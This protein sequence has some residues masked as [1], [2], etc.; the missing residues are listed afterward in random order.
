MR[1]T[2]LVVLTVV[3]IT[4]SGLSTAWADGTTDPELLYVGPGVGT[5]CGGTSTPSSC[6]VYNGTEVVGLGASPT[7]LDVSLNGTSNTTLENPILLII[8]I[9]TVS[10]SPTGSAPSTIT[11]PGGGTAYLGGNG[12]GYYGWSGA[13]TSTTFSSSSGTVYNALGLIPQGSNSQ[14]FTNWQSAELAVN[15]MTATDFGIYVYT[16]F[17]TPS[18]KGGSSFNVDFV[19]SALP[20]GTFAVAYGCSSWTSVGQMPT[21]DSVGKTYST[22]FTQSGLV[23]GTTPVP[24]PGSL[25]L[26]GTGLLGLGGIVR[27]KFRV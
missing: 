4:I 27:R 23:D 24:E 16:L 22:P 5:T 12:S 9:P 8:G 3:A 21:C 25:I 13:A 20:Q 18:L 10:G 26:L 15:G 17:P 19:G 14:S 6:Y 7:S 1:K 11:L 2:I